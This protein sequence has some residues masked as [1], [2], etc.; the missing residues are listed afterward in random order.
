MRCPLF[1]KVLLS[2]VRKN[3]SSSCQK[4]GLFWICTLKRFRP[5]RWRGGHAGVWEIFTWG[6]VCGVQRDITPRTI[7]S[8]A[9]KWV[10]CLNRSLQILCW[11]I[12]L[13]EL[14]EAFYTTSD[15][16]DEL[17][18]HVSY[19]KV[20][21]IVSP[22][23]VSIQLRVSCTECL[24]AVFS[25]LSW[26]VVLTQASGKWFSETVL[27]RLLV[28]DCCFSVQTSVLSTQHRAGTWYSHRESYQVRDKA[29]IIFPEGL[30][31]ESDSYNDS[32]GFLMAIVDHWISIATRKGRQAP[33][34]SKNLVCEIVFGD[35]NFSPPFFWLFDKKWRGEFF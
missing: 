17:W 10:Y 32:A 6:S 14:M 8:Y 30:D 24:G 1:E 5:G 15:S 18:Y 23:K 19:F 9:S 13:T 12:I 11:Y 4:V 29:V 7:N 27:L 2:Q 3:H 28:L 16:H 20:L 35:F 21:D 25:T 31:I 34:Q 22:A 26:Q 33:E